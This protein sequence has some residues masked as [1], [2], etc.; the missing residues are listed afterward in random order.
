MSLLDQL[1][2]HGIV[3]S[4]IRGG[5]EGHD[6]AVAH[7]AE[8]GS[9]PF[10]FGNERYHRSSE[11]AKELIEPAGFRTYMVGGGHR[12]NRDGVELWFATAKGVDISQR[13]SF[14][15]TTDS[16]VHAGT[17]NVQPY[18][19]GLDEQDLPTRPIIHVV[20][21]G[22]NVNGMTAVHLGRLGRISPG[23]VD[24]REIVRIDSLAGHAP[25]TRLSDFVVPKRSYDD[26]PVP[27]FDLAP[28]TLVQ[29][30]ADDE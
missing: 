11:I 28:L 1:D 4:L 21:S 9:N 25:D 7:S 19:D 6:I 20:W 12:A 15:F 29:A 10:T 23:S 22:D 13:T 14:D 26:Q 17:S 27:S 30:T 16:R 2:L 24:W 3:D 5:G 8:R 18:M